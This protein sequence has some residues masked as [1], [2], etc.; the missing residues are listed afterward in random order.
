VP[1]NIL[2]ENLKKRDHSSN[3]VT[4]DDNIKTDVRQVGCEGVYWIELGK[5]TVQ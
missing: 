1:T 5:E 3:R 4:D 2:S